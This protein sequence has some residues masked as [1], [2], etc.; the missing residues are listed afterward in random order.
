[1]CGREL[2]P[3]LG[4]PQPERADAARNRR[5]II[6][7]A[8]RLIAERGAH[9]LSL[10]EVAREAGVGV[11][12]VYRRF[13]D[14]TGLVWALIDEH[15]RRFQTAFMTG[16]PPVGPGAPPDARLRAFLR[17]L[18]DRMVTQQDI[19]LQLELG[20]A[21]GRYS[22]PYRIHHTHVAAL[23][24]EARPDIDAGFFAD[25][26]LAP[27]N[28]RLIRFQLEERGM[29]AEEVKS[30]LDALTDAVLHAPPDGRGGE[31]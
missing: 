12:T 9:Q 2:L 27:V 23:L 1:M 10:D 19:H 25:A 14:R 30:G 11:G 4:Q 17:A 26:L 31:A 5:R 18:V 28:V 6:D 15:E 7:V 24:N 21:K 29:S 16:P 3:V 22:G 20:A 8:S 13:G